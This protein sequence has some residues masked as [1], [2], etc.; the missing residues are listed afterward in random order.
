MVPTKDRAFV[1]RVWNQTLAPG[2]DFCTKAHADF[3]ADRA[4]MRLLVLDPS[5]TKTVHTAEATEPCRCAAFEILSAD[6]LL[7]ANET[8]FVFADTIVFA[9]LTVVVDRIIASANKRLIQTLHFVMFPPTNRVQ[10]HC[11][12][13]T[14]GR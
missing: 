10:S 8:E 4:W 1:V 3:A 2:L 6:C 14:G 11:L 5:E 7:M 13:L 9:W 12:L